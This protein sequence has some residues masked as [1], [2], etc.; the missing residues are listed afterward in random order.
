MRGRFLVKPTF[1]G[2]SG[3]GWCL[4]S[5]SA[6][7]AGSSSTWAELCSVVI[8]PLRWTDAI[9]DPYRLPV[10]QTSWRPKSVDLGIWRE[11][12][13][14]M[15]CSA[16]LKPA[17]GDLRCKWSLH[18][19]FLANRGE[20]LALLPKKEITI[21][22]ACLYLAVSSSAENLI[23]LG[24]AQG[25]SIFAWCFADASTWLGPFQIRIVAHRRCRTTWVA[26]SLD[27]DA[28]VM[29]FDHHKAFGT[30]M[31]QS[32][33]RCCHL[34]FHVQLNATNSLVC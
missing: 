4:I 14:P 31:I 27:R 12:K 1:E 24:C 11:M 23:S 13:R 2:R 32:S 21:L 26:Q 34:R 15:I 22:G 18:V 7:L 25:F 9:D 28:V 16:P 6:D 5:P 30:L 20:S 10:N 33:T 8:A 17:V 3:R 19:L 29:T